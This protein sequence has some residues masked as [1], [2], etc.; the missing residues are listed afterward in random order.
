MASFEWDEVKN[1]ENIKKHGVNFYDAQKAFLDPN[2]LI[3]IDKSH[4]TNKEI[5][6]FCYGKIKNKVCTVRFTYRQ[7]KIRIFGAGYWRKEKKTY[8]KQ[9]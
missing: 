3:L 8:E 6:Y 4:S 1:K 9:V 2:H 5:R 7:N